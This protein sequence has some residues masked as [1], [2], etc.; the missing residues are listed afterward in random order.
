[1]RQF[2][3]DNRREFL[4]GLR[5]GEEAGVDSQN[6]P[7]H[8]EGIKGGTFYN[9]NLEASIIELAVLRQAIDMVFQVII[10]K[11]VTHNRRSRAQYF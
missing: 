2:V 8:G 4:L 11:R 6:P 7:R 5:I 9:H 10:D 3:S 1:M